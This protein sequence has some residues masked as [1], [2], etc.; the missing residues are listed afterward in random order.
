MPVGQRAAPDEAMT[1][2]EFKVLRETLGLAAAWVARKLATQE[3][4]V[5]RWET[6]VYGVNA[7]AAQLLRDVQAETAE[8]VT[9]M[10]TRVG[11]IDEP[12]LY[13]Y[14]KDAEFVYAGQHGPYTAQWHR[15]LVGRVATLAAKP[16]RI[17]FVDT[18]ES[19]GE[20][21]L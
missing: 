6:G 10:L 12:V 8:C 7:D 15:A 18:T 13:T 2:A 9:Q 1:A 16:V 4:S 5:S 11:E 14:R 3:K 20:T 17:E 21:P 19:E